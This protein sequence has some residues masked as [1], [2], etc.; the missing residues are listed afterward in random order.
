MRVGTSRVAVLAAAVAAAV[1][2]AAPA[3]AQVVAELVIDDV[4]RPT[5]VVHAGDGSGRLFVTTQDGVVWVWN[6]TSKSVFLDLSAANG[7]PVLFA[8]EQ[9]L[10]GIAFDP[11]YTSNGRFFVYYANAANDMVLARYTVSGNPDVANPVGTT[12]LTID[13]PSTAHNHRAGRIEFGPDG[14]LYVTTGDGGNTPEQAQD[15]TSLRGKILRL[16]VSGATYTV[17]PTNPFVG[18]SGRGEIW[19]YGLRNPWRLSFDTLTG[20][21]FIADVGGATRE[22]VNFQP[23]A[24]GGGQNYGWPCR[25]GL[26]TGPRV[27][28]GTFTDPILDYPHGTGDCS[29]TGGFRYRG[30]SIPQWLGKYVYADYCTGIVRVGT[31]GAGGTWTAAV[32]LDLPWN[33]STFGLDEDGELYVNSHVG[34]QIYRL[35]AAPTVSISDAPVTEGSGSAVMAEFAVTTSHATSVAQTVAWT[36]QPGTAA[37]GAD[38]TAASGT[39]T[40]PAGSM[41]P[42]T[43]SIPVAGDV[44]D[45]DDETFQ[46]VLTSAT[47]AAIGDGTGV[48]TITDDDPTP[49]IGVGDAIVTEGN[50]GTATATFPVTLAAPSGRTVTLDWMTMPASATAAD[51]VAASGR[52]TLPPGATSGA[53]QVSVLG[54]TID[55]RHEAFLLQLTA[56]NATLAASMAQGTIRDDDGRVATCLPIA[57][58]PFRILTQGRYCLARNVSTSQT[59]GHAISIE[60]DSVVLDLQGF[61]LGGGAAG[62][63][64]N[65]TG[66]HALDRRNVVVR[67][68]NVRGFRWGVRLPSL[69]NSQG[70]VVEGIL[71]DANTYMGILVQGAG[72]VVRRNAVLATGGSTQA[73]DNDAFGIAVGGTGVRVLDNDVSGTFPTGAGVATGILA[74]AA[75]GAVVEKN[76]VGGGG[77]GAGIVAEVSSA[78]V[79]VLDNRLLQLDE[80]IA[81]RSGADGVYRRNLTTGV[82]TPFTGGTDAGGNQ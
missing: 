53:I 67:N 14:Y 74:T 9:G 46:V 28:S 34:N 39:V 18:T 54:D 10:L 15:L 69:G 41:A 51:Y 29:I 36:T 59:S 80:G 76:R 30:P 27:C 7:G 35:T 5:N 78:D 12:I 37:A 57:T 82:A 38:F 1:L 23:A 33:V 65:A 42:L 21:L 77:S 19:A 17:P 16:D 25:E 62:L 40:F 66:I 70:N 56:G 8:G 71:A 3:T 13:Q 4:F 50:A 81:F 58:V 45:E 75:S 24:S 6:G 47:N 55:E 31:E 49:V 48:A 60:A 22:E 43:I 11:A 79:L 52:V 32:G 44:L 20:D 68:G 63:A 64:T 72:G 26:T 61:K 73:A 2:G